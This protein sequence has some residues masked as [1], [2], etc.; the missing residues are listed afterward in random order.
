MQTLAQLAL[1]AVALIL[2]AIAMLSGALTSSSIGFV[3]PILID[4]ADHVIA[5]LGSIRF[6]ALI[7]RREVSAPVARNQIRPA[8]TAT[9]WRRG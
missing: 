2:L 8:K 6:L 7:L 5:P 1:S 9:C 3:L 4:E